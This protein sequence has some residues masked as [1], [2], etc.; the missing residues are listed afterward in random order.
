MELTK[1]KNSNKFIN[2][3]EM[4]DPK[5][6]NEAFNNSHTKQIDFRLTNL[7]QNIY[8]NLGDEITEIEINKLVF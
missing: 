4:I 3:G 1:I 7:E 2:S 5:L 8:V 6:I